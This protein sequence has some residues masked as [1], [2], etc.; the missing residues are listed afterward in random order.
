MVHREKPGKV[1]CIGKSKVLTG[2]MMLQLILAI[3]LI[4]LRYNQR[5]LVNRYNPRR[6]VKHTSGYVCEG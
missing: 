6:L 5:R 2:V 1:Y 4:I 3:N